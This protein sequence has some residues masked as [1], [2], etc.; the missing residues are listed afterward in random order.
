[1]MD[2]KLVA[3][4]AAFAAEAHALQTRKELNEAYIT[5]PLRVGA[6]A[7][8]L[9]APDYVIAA[10]Y[11]HDVLEDTPMEA[12]DLTAFPSGTVRLVRLLTK[13]P[14]SGDPYTN[15]VAKDIYYMNIEKENYAI[16]LK[17]LDR[18]DNLRDMIRTAGRS[19]SM[20][21]W[22]SR[23]MA[24]T[25]KEFVNIRAKCTNKLAVQWYDETLAK[26]AGELAK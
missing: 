1:M 25:L 8:Q 5:H 3:D 12:D 21:R 16:L 7:A 15:H 14:D 26:L 23:Y 10:A 22:A 6:M 20:S 2:I 17:I 11:L 13:T 19:P 4:A 24:K 9:G 18:I